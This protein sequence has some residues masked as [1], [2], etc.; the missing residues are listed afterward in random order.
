MEQ[1]QA[2]LDSGDSE[3]EEAGITDEMLMEA[4]KKVRGKKAVLKE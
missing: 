1:D 4:V 3:M 2:D